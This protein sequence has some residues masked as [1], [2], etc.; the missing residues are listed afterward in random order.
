MA[1]LKALKSVLKPMEE[2]ISAAGDLSALLFH[3]DSFLQGL[4]AGKAK[5]HDSCG[6]PTMAGIE[7]FRVAL[8]DDFYLNS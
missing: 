5:I 4:F 2:L 1:Q 7:L 8:F 3:D 6:V